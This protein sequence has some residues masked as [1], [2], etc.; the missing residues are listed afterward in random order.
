MFNVSCFMFNVICVMLSVSLSVSCYLCLFFFPLGSLEVVVVVVVVVTELGR[1][2]PQ[3]SHS[4]FIIHHHHHHHHHHSSFEDEG[5]RMKDER[6]HKDE[7]PWKKKN[8]ER[9]N[10][11]TGRRST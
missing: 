1:S 11:E 2:K 6:C 10:G 4:S 3:S 5:R 7:S 9:L 8:A